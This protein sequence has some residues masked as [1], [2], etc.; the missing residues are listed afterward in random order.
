MERPPL[1]KSSVFRIRLNTFRDLWRRGY[2]LTCG[3]KFGC[4]YLAYESAPGEVSIY[5]ILLFVETTF[6]LILF[7]DDNSYHFL[8]CNDKR[9][10]FWGHVFSGSFQV[11]SEMCGF[12]RCFIFLRSYCAVKAFFSSEEAC[13]ASC[14]LTRH[15]ITLLYWIFLVEIP[16]TSKC[17]AALTTNC[18]GM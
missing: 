4:D 1:P 16:A 14:C 17:I 9:C 6:Y 13:L 3:L 2:Y 15:F 5:A 10:C 18:N 7:S 8:L 12:T 11:V